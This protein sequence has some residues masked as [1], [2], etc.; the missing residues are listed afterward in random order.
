MLK[1]ILQF[2]VALLRISQGIFLISLLDDLHS[3]RLKISRLLLQ[4][5]QLFSYRIG[6]RRRRF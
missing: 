5:I 1:P 2:L 4:I 3:T 6:S